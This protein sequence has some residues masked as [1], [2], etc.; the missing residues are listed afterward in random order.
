[1][2]PK[3][4]QKTIALS[5][6]ATLK[7]SSA[8]KRLRIFE[9]ITSPGDTAATVRDSDTSESEEEESRGGKE[10]GRSIFEWHKEERCK[11]VTDMKK[12]RQQSA[13]KAINT[14]SS[15]EDLLSLINNTGLKG[16]TE[17]ENKLEERNDE[18]S[19]VFSLF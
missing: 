13:S 8:A 17:E 11:R 18:D 12:P 2:K 7:E 15:S 1:M 19:S 3:R 10:L 4:R 9:E 14:A 16:S 5:G 6:P